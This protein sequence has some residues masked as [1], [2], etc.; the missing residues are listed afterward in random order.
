TFLRGFTNRPPASITE[1]PFWGFRRGGWLRLRL[2][3]PLGFSPPFSLCITHVF[4]GGCTHLSPF[5][6]W[7]FRCSGWFRAATREHGP[8]FGNLSVDAQLLL[9]KTFDGGSQDFRSKL[10]RHVNQ[11][12]SLDEVRRDHC[13][14]A[15]N[16]PHTRRHLRIFGIC[17]ESP[18]R[19]E[20]KL[21]SQIWRN[22]VVPFR[23]C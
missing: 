22:G 21:T 17:G 20:S 10:L 15:T 11:S 12:N 5:S 18:L 16:L 19:D 14:S 4:P 1:L 3:W 6:F 7:S 13:T 2:G 9:F 8:E 23:Q